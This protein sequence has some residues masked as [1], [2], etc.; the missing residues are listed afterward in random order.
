MTRK[1][2]L[3]Q[4]VEKLSPL[5]EDAGH[6]LPYLIVLA[7][8][9]NDPSTVDFDTSSLH[10]IITISNSLDDKTTVAE[11]LIHNILFRAITSVDTK[12]GLLAGEIGFIG[13][14][15][16]GMKL[17][18]RIHQLVEEMPPY[19]EVYTREK[20]LKLFTHCMRPWFE[21]AGHPLPSIE[22]HQGRI[23]PNLLNHVVAITEDGC[24]IFIPPALSNTLSL[25][26]LLTR[27]FVGCVEAPC[28]ESIGIVDGCTTENLI[29]HFKST[30][31]QIGPYPE[32]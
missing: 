15:P 32:N 29:A 8:D 30:I 6:Q 13:Y 1:E 12:Q 28:A 3:T 2:W 18:G 11:E 23:L 4:L 16:T 21:A 19:P 5:F 7:Q 17:L 22:I 26:K 27:A 14:M 9:I 25:A 10:W 31:D 24:Y 20:W